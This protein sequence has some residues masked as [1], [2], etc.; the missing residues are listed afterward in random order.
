MTGFLCVCVC[1]RART[2]AHTHLTPLEKRN[3]SVVFVVCGLRKLDCPN[4]FV[5]GVL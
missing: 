2:H 1:V 3:G 4:A 5:N